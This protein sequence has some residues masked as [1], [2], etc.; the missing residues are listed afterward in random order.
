MDVP[1][2]LTCLYKLCID[3][4]KL[5]DLGPVIASMVKLAFALF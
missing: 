2:D 5:N 1:Y 4:M 3:I